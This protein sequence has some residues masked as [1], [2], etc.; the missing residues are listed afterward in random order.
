ME[1]ASILERNHLD[2]GSKFKMIKTDYGKIVQKT[3]IIHLN[4]SKK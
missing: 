1:A 3:N 4:Y 2:I